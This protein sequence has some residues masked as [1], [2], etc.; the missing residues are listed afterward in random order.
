MNEKV[1]KDNVQKEL[2]DTIYELPDLPKLELSDG[3][4]KTLGVEVDDVRSRIRQ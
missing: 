2:D 4:L 1:V 3:L